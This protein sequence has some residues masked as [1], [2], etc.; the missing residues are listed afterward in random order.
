MYLRFVW[1]RGNLRYMGAGLGKGLRG[2]G[3]REGAEGFTN[4][5][6]VGEGAVIRPHGAG[7]V[8]VEGVDLAA[9]LLEG[10]VGDLLEAGLAVMLFG[11]G[12]GIGSGAV[13]D[14]GIHATGATHAPGGLGHAVNEF[15]FDIVA[16][17]DETE[18]GVKQLVIGPRQLVVEDDV[19]VAG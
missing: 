16:R 8:A 6:K 14:G 2:P 1:K 15:L 17:I 11:D 13:Q 18:V 7:V 19:L 9:A 5:D 12:F 10:E 4:Q 3:G